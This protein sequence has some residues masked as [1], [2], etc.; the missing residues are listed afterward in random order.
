MEAVVFDI[1]QTLTYYPI[2]LNWSALY[3][4][5]FE[6]IKNVDCAKNVGAIAVLINRAMKKKITV[7]IIRS[8]V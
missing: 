2:P 8:R 3:R 4:P 5:A 1:G 7:R 6:H